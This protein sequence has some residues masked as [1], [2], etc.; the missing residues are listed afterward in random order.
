MPDS[1]L[2]DTGWGLRFREG[3]RWMDTHDGYPVIVDMGLFV[4]LLLC[5][6]QSVFRPGPYNASGV[7]GIEG[8]D[9]P[10]SVCSR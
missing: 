6:R 4:Q 2:R 9:V 8:I 7:K 1:R 5:G 10:R 3:R